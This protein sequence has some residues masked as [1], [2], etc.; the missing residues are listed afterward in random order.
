M[1]PCVVNVANGGGYPA[2]QDRL[3]N[4]LKNVGYLGARS[5]WRDSLPPGAPTHHDV[6]YAFKTHALLHAE[7][8]LGVNML[9]WAD[10]SMVAVN[11]ISPIMLHAAKQGVCLWRA[12]WTVG[13]WTSDAALPKL[14][15]GREDAMKVPLL[16]GG[17]MAI[18]LTHPKGRKF[19]DQWHAFA[20]DG[21][22]FRG[23][24]NNK[25]NGASTDNRVL[26]HRHDMPSISVIAQRLSIVPV[27]CPKWF[28]YDMGGPPPGEPI[29]LARGL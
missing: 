23:P 13:Q 19:L 3:D 24:W 11:D 7:R 9:I 8:T 5:Y 26:G 27:D 28:A 22:S 6:P 18:D 12:G 4:S 25:G 29:F 16:V 17:L 10:A 2:G 21:V 20:T 1:K 15:I 14:G